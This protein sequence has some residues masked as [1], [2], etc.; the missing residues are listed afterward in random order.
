MRGRCGT[1]A[2]TV[3]LGLLWNCGFGKLIKTL[4]SISLE[5]KTPHILN[6]CCRRFRNAGL[7]TPHFMEMPGFDFFLVLEVFACGPFDSVSLSFLT[8]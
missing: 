4:F 1:L 7:K 2:G 5:K 3:E 8:S 6:Y